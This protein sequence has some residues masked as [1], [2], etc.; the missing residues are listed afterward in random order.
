MHRPRHIEVIREGTAVRVL[1]DGQELPAIVDHDAVTVPVAPD[2]WPTV[3]LTLYADRITVTNTP[4][5]ATEAA[6]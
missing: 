2:D 1:V 4:F 5:T 3:Q 6:R